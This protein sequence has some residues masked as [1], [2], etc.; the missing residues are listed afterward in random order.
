[1]LLSVILVMCVL[2]FTR[3]HYAVITT[4]LLTINMVVSVNLFN[5][6]SLYVVGMSLFAFIYVYAYSK[7]NSIT[8]MTNVNDCD[9]LELSRLK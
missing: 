6:Y 7:I 9:E 2:I 8:E 4:I 1:M 5:E 3:P